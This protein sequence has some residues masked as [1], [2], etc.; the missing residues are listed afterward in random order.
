MKKVQWLALLMVVAILG[1]TGFQLYWLKDNYAREKK[2]L[3][4]KTDMGFH[5]TI[6]KLQG[7]KLKLDGVKWR[8]SLRPGLKIIMSGD[9]EKH[10]RLRNTTGKEEIISTVNIISDKLKDSMRKKGGRE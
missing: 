2:S 1:I 6:R 7:A 10:M 4:I 5:E 8:D 9:D 3:L